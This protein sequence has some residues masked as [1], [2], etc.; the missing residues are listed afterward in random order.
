MTVDAPP[1]PWH[2][3]AAEVAVELRDSDHVI[4]TERAPAKITGPG[5]VTV[6]VTLSGLEDITLWDT[7]RPKLYHVVAG[8][9]PR[10]ARGTST[11]CGSGS[12]RPGSRWTGST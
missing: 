1:L 6:T 8:C 9:W 5:R 3:T 4:A 7:G 10:P 2:L 12:A 11:G